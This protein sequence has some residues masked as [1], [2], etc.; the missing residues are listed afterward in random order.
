MNTDDHNPAL[1]VLL[2]RLLDIPQEFQVDPVIASRGKVHI[3]ALAHDFYRMH[4]AAI[5]NLASFNRFVSNDPDQDRNRLQL[6]MVLIW[7]L[8]D[9]WFV[10][11][12][13]PSNELDGL[14]GD[15]AEE[16]SKQANA[17]AFIHDADRREELVRQC[18]YRLDLRPSGET[19]DQAADRLSSISSIKRQLLLAESREA[20]ARARSIREA[21]IRKAA[22][23]S[24][25]KW[26][27][28]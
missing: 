24:A 2:Q 25:D 23:A 9:P 4:Q 26:G 11:R 21:L 6:I 8:S 14:L 19:A 18:L 17:Q 1:E 15:M 7:L 3:A 20:Q 13:L 10:Q 22:E 28:E 12:R 5:P 16:L 27:R